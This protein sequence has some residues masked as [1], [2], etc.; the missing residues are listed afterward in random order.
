LDCSSKEEDEES[1]TRTRRRR[2]GRRGKEIY[3]VVIT[4]TKS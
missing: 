4:K 1:R 3:E 2:T